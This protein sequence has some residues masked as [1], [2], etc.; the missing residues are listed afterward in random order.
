MTSLTPNQRGILALITAMACFTA[1]DALLKLAAMSL[2]A[3]QIMAVRGL[4]ASMLALALVAAVGAIRQLP[5]LLMPIVLARGVLEGL[6]AFLFITALEHLPLAIITS[7][8]Q[9]S[10]ILLTLM[11]VMLGFEKVGW[12]RWGA[13]VIGFFGVVLVAQ[14]DISGVNPAM[15]IALAAAF[16][17]ACREL[18]TSRLKA[19]IPSIVVTLSA[20]A[21]VGLIGALIALAPGAAAWQ[22]LDM[23]LIA[24]LIVAAFIVTAGN[25]GLIIAFRDTDVSVVSPF[26][27]SIIPWAI[28]AGYITF[29]EVPNALAVSGIALIIA[30]GVY[31]TWRE[32]VRKREAARQGNPA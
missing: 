32:Q 10:P 31:S 25:Y 22:P 16:F 21:S 12:R 13:I 29:G 4:F 11:L 26:R 17:A 2:P 6:I 3:S 15:L 24:L 5:R 18:L 9:A 7:I 27:Y 20:A 19:E 23:P 8:L 28:L 30:A 14:P 1:N